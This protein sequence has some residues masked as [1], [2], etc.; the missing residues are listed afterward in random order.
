VSLASALTLANVTITQ[1]FGKPSA[2][3][4]PSAANYFL[5]QVC[6]PVSDKMYS[7]HYLALQKH[8]LGLETFKTEINI[9][10]I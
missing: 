8:Q 5:E 4:Y 10:Y 7:A 1:M 9:Y 2:L 3:T 6:D